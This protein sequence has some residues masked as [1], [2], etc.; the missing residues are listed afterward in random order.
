LGEAALPA[1]ADDIFL[2]V[3]GHPP[4]APGYVPYAFLTARARGELSPSR[5]VVADGQLRVEAAKL[6]GVAHLS[7]RVRQ[8]TEADAQLY[9][10][11]SN[12]DGACRRSHQ[13]KARAVFLCVTHPEASGLANSKIA[14]H[15]GVSHGLVKRIRRAVEGRWAESPAGQGA[16][17]LPP[18]ADA[19]DRLV[20]WARARRIH[21]VAQAL[22][23]SVQELVAEWR[24][25][26]PP[27]V[28]AAAA[29]GT[30]EEGPGP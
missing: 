5:F 23:L 13:D 6:A 12:R 30:G 8:G 22:G 25:A 18:D 28:A 14:R 1:S 3:K 10:A 29:G 17:E 24:R 11:G 9:A 20:L 2:A 16:V 26:E 27:A 15:T 7:C 19:Q 4:P 21:A